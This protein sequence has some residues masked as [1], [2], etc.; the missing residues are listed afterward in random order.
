MSAI[1]RLAQ[2]LQDFFPTLCTY[3]HV[4]LTNILITS[5]DLH[6]DCNVRVKNFLNI[7]NPVSFLKL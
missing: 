2:F 3:I 6:L 7:L 4:N 5:Y 1:S